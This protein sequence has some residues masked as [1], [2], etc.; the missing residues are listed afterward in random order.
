MN[1]PK[2]N[3]GILKDN[4]NIQTN[5]A[6]CTNCNETFK[7]S[8]NI[9][10][11]FNDGFDMNDSPKGTWIKMEMNNLIIGATTR[12]PIAF[13]LVPFMI[14][15]SGASIGGIYGGQISKGEVDPF[16]AIFGIPFIMG[17]ILFWSLTLL[18][19]WGKVELTLDRNG[20]RVFTGLGIFGVSNNFKW[21]EI[22]LIKE[23]KENN[24][25]SGSQ[26]SKLTLEGKKKISFGWGVNESRKYYLYR[27]MK[28]IIDKVKAN[29]SFTY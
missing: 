7:I 17:S 6:F 14:V 9:P 19:I 11:E 25:N 5:I 10:T 2:C 26:G 12:S 1:C 4:I 21:D 16:L 29:K 20:G 15:W 8:E 28:I 27:S 3:Y 18:T 22:S 13:F 23:S 24:N